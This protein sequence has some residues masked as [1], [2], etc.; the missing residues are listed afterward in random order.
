MFTRYRK[1]WAHRGRCT[2]TAKW[3]G[4]C[5]IRKVALERKVSDY[6]QSPS[7]LLTCPWMGRSCRGEQALVK[8]PPQMEFKS[9]SSFG[10][11]N[12]SWSIGSS[13]WFGNG[14]KMDFREW[15]SSWMCVCVC[16]H[17]FH[18]WASLRS[19][20]GPIDTWAFQCPPPR[21][22]GNTDRSPPCRAPG[23]GEMC[24]SSR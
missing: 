17:L 18:S 15:L 8:F 10:A 11:Q 9:S 12:C 6:P 4:T 16:F 2:K 3:N 23:Q 14:V 5:F 21:S 1:V 7:S 19:R 13:C 22:P 24:S 20:S